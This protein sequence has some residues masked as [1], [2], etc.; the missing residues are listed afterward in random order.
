M[1]LL[2]LPLIFSFP[3]AICNCLYTS[4]VRTSS[5]TRICIVR[6]AHGTTIALLISFYICPLLLAFFLHGKLIYFIRSRHNQ[7]YFT[8]T[9][10]MLST[11]RNETIEL[12]SRRR[13]DRNRFSPN[14]KLL[15]EPQGQSHRAKR[16]ITTT[17]ILPSTT[18][19]TLPARIIPNQSSNSS[20]SSRSSTGTNC[21]SP[22]SPIIL[23]K[24]NSQANANAN[25]TVLLLVLLLSFYVFC[26]APYNI[27]TWRHAHLYAQPSS[28]LNMKENSNMSSMNDSRRKFASFVSMSVNADLRRIIYVN[29][30]LYLLS[31]V[32]MCFSFIFYFSLNKQARH[33]FSQFIGCLCP[34]VNSIRTGKHRS[35]YSKASRPIHQHQRTPHPHS[36]RIY[37]MNNNPSPPSLVNEPSTHVPKRR[38]LNY[39]CHIQCCP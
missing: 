7:Y 17:E 21:T 30:S 2:I 38:I 12:Q 5:G 15:S 8:P 19:T 33:E 29:Y 11:K 13:I 35:K 31:M 6:Y 23:Y 36:Y 10:Y 16:I 1:L 9:P 26:W 27:Y 4:I 14:M 28:S 34:W 39:G 18:T 37:R 25:R 22:M 3:L 24:I 32:S 20:Q